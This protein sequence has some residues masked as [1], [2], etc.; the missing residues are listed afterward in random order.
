[1]DPLVINHPYWFFGLL[2]G[3]AGTLTL[4]CWLLS[5]KNTVVNPRAPI[6]SSAPATPAPRVSP[7]KIEEAPK[8]IPKHIAPKPPSTSAPVQ[9]APIQT[10]DH[11][12][13]NNGTNLGSQKVEDNRTYGASKP[14]PNI[15]D[16]VVEQVSG[17]P[18]PDPASQ[19]N[20]PFRTGPREFGPSANPGLK[21][22]FRVDALFLNP[23]FL[24]RCDHPCLGSRLM[25][26]VNGSGGYSGTPPFSQT[27]NPNE[28]LVNSGMTKMIDQNTTVIIT[29]RSRDETPINS[30]TVEGFIQ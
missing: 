16:L 20:S 7:P 25:F 1:M 2:I 10:A 14:A 23:M 22:T 24:V 12:I 4:G 6:V 30:A 11:G 18:R 19:S 28:V 13:I 17:I 9:P 15:V 29:V 26:L 8:S 21:L 5:S 27:Q 3:F